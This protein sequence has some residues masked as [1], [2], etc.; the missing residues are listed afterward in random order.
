MAEKATRVVGCLSALM[1]NLGGPT[2]IRGRMLMDVVMS[3][4]LYGAPVWADSL[5]IAFRR[6]EMEKVQRRSIVSMNAL[7]VLARTPPI[8]LLAE[9][10]AEVLERKKKKK[11][12]PARRSLLVKWKDYLSS[13]ATGD[14]T[15]TLIRD[16][17][18]WMNRGHGQLNFHLTQVLSGHGCFNE[19]LFRMKKVD[20]PSCSHCSR[21]R[22]DGPLHTLFECK[23]WRQDRC[24]LVRSLEEIGVDEEL[25]PATLVPIMLHSAAA[26]DRVSAFACAVMK[27]KMDHEWARQRQA[28]Q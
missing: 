9:E 13:S 2:E 7:C 17:D 4:L 22:N 25:A 27:K 28:C 12:K 1:S 19:Y 6:R 24:E 14:W 10:W 16:L 3:V 5:Q 26:W 11:L 23:A 18:G 8:R 15:R 20:S 21:G